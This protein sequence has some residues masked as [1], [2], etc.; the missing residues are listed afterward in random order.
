MVYKVQFS[1][2]VP[3]RIILVSTK[4]HLIQNKVSPGFEMIV[5][6]HSKVTKRKSSDRGLKHTNEHLVRGPINT[7]V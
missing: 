3:P 2:S 7:V 6:P 4:H 1:D 5:F